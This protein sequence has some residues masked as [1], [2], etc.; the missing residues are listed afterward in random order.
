V[1]YQLG[2]PRQ[3]PA[4]V[5]ELQ[6]SNQWWHFL[7]YLWLIY[8]NEGANDLYSRVVRH[9]AQSDGL[10]VVEIKRRAQVQGWLPK[11]AWDWINE[12]QN[13]LPLF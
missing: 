1:T 4:L 6:N 10:L 5:A 7:D 8:S 9:M 11:E 13:S 2:P 3:V 12:K